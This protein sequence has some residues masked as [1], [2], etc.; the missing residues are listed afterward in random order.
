MIEK[1]ILDYLTTKLAP[2]PVYMEVPV[3][4]A[5]GEFVVV[6]KTG[7]GRLNNI[8]RASL[9]VQSYADSL[10]DAAVLNEAVKAAMFDS[11]TLDEVSRCELNSDYNFTD[12]ATKHYR[13]QAI[14]N[15]TH[16]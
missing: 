14:F 16:Y 2:V 15:L 8:N 12:T 4:G 9:A 3:D 6:E 13:Y 7:G 10:Y 5:V 11:V 1:I